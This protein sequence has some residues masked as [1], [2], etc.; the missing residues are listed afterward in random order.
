MAVEQNDAQ[1]TMLKMA[2]ACLTLVI[3]HLPA[4]IEYHFRH[5]YGNDFQI[6]FAKEPPWTL[7][8][9]FYL[10]HKHWLAVFREHYTAGSISQPTNSLKNGEQVIKKWLRERRFQTRKDKRAICVDQE[11]FINPQQP[12]TA[13]RTDDV[14]A[15]LQSCEILIQ[16]FTVDQSH[17][18]QVLQQ[19]SQWQYQLRCFQ[20]S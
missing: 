7:Q 13:L 8:D 6:M 20:Q 15:V 14:R 9:L 1:D 10:M 17:K 2:Q 4:A 12:A 19:I 18:D 11:I 3:Q 16:L 5:A